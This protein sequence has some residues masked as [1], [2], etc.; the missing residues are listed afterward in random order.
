MNSESEIVNSSILILDNYDSF[1]YNLK[2]YLDPLVARVDVLR[3]DAIDMDALESY[4]GIVLSP[5][6]GLPK[7]AG[8][9]MG[10]IARYAGVVPILGVCLGHQAIGEFY[11]AKLLNMPTVLHGQPSDCELVGEDDLF[12]ACD[13]P[14]LIG[15]YH[16]WVVDEVG[17][18]PCLEVTARS[19]DAY[20][21]AMRHREQDVCGVQF[22]P[23]S[24]LTPDGKKILANWVKSISKT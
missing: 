3:N 12:D 4:D 20:I 24:I 14:L 6:P 5:G 11:G 15:H 13:R 22:H 9:M 17:L 18:P 23:E 10:L 21:M 19:T 8:L 2:H 16:S 1:T 7:D